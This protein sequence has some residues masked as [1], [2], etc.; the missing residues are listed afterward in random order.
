ML[1]IT[2]KWEVVKNILLSKRFKSFYW[3]SGAMLV[4][5]FISVILES[6]SDLQLSNFTIVLLGL[7]LGE[8]SKLLNT[9]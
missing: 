7:I 2:T 9:K 5:G 4:S 3:R 8:I 6:A 1:H